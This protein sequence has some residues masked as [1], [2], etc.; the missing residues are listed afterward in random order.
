ML[1]EPVETENPRNKIRHNIK[2][3][4]KILLLLTS[5]G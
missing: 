5:L 4:R 3:A 1:D 2:A